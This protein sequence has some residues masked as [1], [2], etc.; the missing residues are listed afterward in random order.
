[1]KA[2]QFLFFVFTLIIFLL[3]GVVFYGIAKTSNNF[4]VKKAIELQNRSENEKIEQNK[5]IMM[6]KSDILDP[7]DN[8]KFAIADIF[9]KNNQF[10]KAEEYLK[11]VKSE[12]GY[13]KYAE[14]ALES[15]QYKIADIYIEKVKNDDIKSELKIF[16][17]FSK[18]NAD[19]LKNLPAIPLTELGKLTKAIN[20]NDFE[21]ATKSSI[22]EKIALIKSKNLKKTNEN[23]E[24]VDMFIKSKQPNV[25]RFMLE[26]LRLNHPGVKD[27]YSLFARSY[28]AENNYEKALEF[29]K[30]GIEIDPSDLSIYN[31]ALNYANLAGD[32]AE[33]NRLKELIKYL[34]KIQDARTCTTCG[35]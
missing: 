16:S 26:Q 33:A 18:G 4:R 23:L 27:V 12:D 14:A 25:A 13:Y 7:N 6:I 3:N 5:V 9:L 35:V 24:I 10:N 29:A 2:R 31:V 21:D 20:T 28:E 19:S 17:D 15:S 11:Q 34:E 8:K 1:M 32:T 30:R 22:G